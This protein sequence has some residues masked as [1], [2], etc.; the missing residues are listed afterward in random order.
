VARWEPLPRRP[1]RSSCSS[2]SPTTT[3]RPPADPEPRSAWLSQTLEEIVAQLRRAFDL[4]GCA[5]VV[6]DWRERYIS[7]A[8]AWFSTPAVAE[9][10]GAVLSRPYDPDRPG[11]TEAAIERRA[12][13]LVDSIEDWPGA[14]G[15]RERLHDQLPA[16]QAELTW[17]WYGASSLLSVPVQAP[18]GRILGVLALSAARFGEEDLRTAEAFA[19]L[20]GIALD[21][22]ELLHREERRAEEEI[23]LN[24]AMQELGR[25]LDLDD[26]YRSIV[27]QARAVSGVS[28]VLLAR[29]E[30]ASRDLRVV[31]SVGASD[32]LRSERFVVGEGM[33]GRVAETGEPYVSRE[34]DRAG[35]LPWI[36]AEE[37]INSFA[38]IPLSIGPR[39]FGVLT[40]ADED[41]RACDE[42]LLVRMVAF[43]RAAAGAIA[44]ALDFQRER[45]VALALTR[46]YVPGPLPE[47]EGFD[48]GLVYSPSGQ[49]AGGGDLFG[50]W[51]LPNGSVAL[52]VGDVSGK[53][54]EVAAI[55][56]MVR[57]FVE[58]RTWDAAD[59]AAVVAQTNALLRR[60]LPGTTFVP[61]VLAVLDETSIR[62]CNAGHPPPVLL[63]ANGGERELTGTGLPLGVDEDA[64]YT[65]EEAPF[66]PG[67][68]LFASTDGLTE[69]RREGRQFGD[70]RLRPLL[71]EHGRA[72][73]PD[74]LV[75]LMHREAE[76]WAPTL[77]DDVVILAL[78]RRG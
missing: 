49:A 74:A 33:I 6:V 20:A 4:T 34:A 22:A 56:A 73:D 14:A 1:P 27:A 29:Q 57:F 75:Q 76:A 60:R 28:T 15:L 5:F 26:V 30:P 68:V 25:S 55:S 19:N 61:I 23:Q 48:A 53:G 31:H 17:E 36:V 51:R 18:A 37:G 16:H 44:N 63:S 8:A 12:P 45:R 38:H 77:D 65:A 7:P 71:A 13:L 35:F 10:F 2:R 58:A 41:P 62:W 24:R 3:I 42:A 21:R 59:P 66:G 11:I 39:L 43:G 47:L 70:E 78:R 9:A 52:L 67:D 64:A 46:G 50:L 54:I 40:V 72:L 32:R 69:A